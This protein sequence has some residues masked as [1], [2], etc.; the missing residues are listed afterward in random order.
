MVIQETGPYY[1]RALKRI[2]M[3]QLKLKDKEDPLNWTRGEFE[4]PLA[5][6][7]GSEVG[8]PSD[9]CYIGESDNQMV[10]RS[11]SVVTPLVSLQ[12]RQGSI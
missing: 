3:D 10:R 12:K 2:T 11:T 1:S 5:K 9:C 8:M 6:A 7:C 4:I